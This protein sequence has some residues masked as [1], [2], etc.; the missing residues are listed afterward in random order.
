MADRKKVLILINASAGVGRAEDDTLEIASAYAKAG[1]EPVVYPIIPGTELISENIIEWYKGE[2]EEVMCCGGDGTLNHVIS[3]V[4]NLEKDERPVIA[5]IP[6]GSTNDFARGLN[7]PDNRDEA[8]EVAVRGKKFTY[9]IGRMNDRYFNYVAAFGAFSKIS[10]DTDQDLKNAFGYAA[11]VINAI[12][13]LPQNI[14]YSC[15]MRIDMGGE[16][17]E[18][19]YVF[20]SVCNSVSVGGMKLF[21]NVGVKLDDGKLELLLIRS[22]KNISELNSI[23]TALAKGDTDNPYI[24]FREIESARFIS[25]EEVSWTLD[26]EY[27]GESRKTEIEVMR[28]AVTIKVGKK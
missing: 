5:Y 2:T 16:T 11:Y 18:G 6:A 24:I 20:G 26:G 8:V 27:G 13:N 17:E 4:M 25:D 14:S 15:K 12:I 19:E 22:P 21:E 28:K 9:D 23:L 10:Y 7:I 1:Y 3:G